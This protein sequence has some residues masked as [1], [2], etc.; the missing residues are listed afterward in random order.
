MSP[1]WRDSAHLTLNTTHKSQH[2]LT[3]AISLITTDH[4]LNDEDLPL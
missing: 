4:P 1:E 3:E 2:Q